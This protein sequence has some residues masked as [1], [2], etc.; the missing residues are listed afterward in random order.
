MRLWR[1]PGIYAGHRRGSALVV[2]G[3]ISQVKGQRARKAERF[4]LAFLRMPN[5]GTVYWWSRVH[6]DYGQRVA[7]SKVAAVNF[8]AA[9]CRTIPMVL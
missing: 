7:K 6:V 3:L 1:E 4:S 9:I 2:L 8:R 5:M